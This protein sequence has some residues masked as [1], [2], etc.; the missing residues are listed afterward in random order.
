VVESYALKPVVTHWGSGD[1][2]TT[3]LLSDY[4]SALAA[5]NGHANMG[6]DWVQ[7]HCASVLGEDYNRADCQLYV[8]LNPPAQDE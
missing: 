4:T 7:A 2:M 8:E 1:A 6:V 5:S 3:Y